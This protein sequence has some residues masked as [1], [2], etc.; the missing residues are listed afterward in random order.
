VGANVPTI[1]R[2]LAVNPADPIDVATMNFAKTAM[3][4]VV[5]PGFNVPIPYSI[6]YGY[7]DLS[8]N[9]PAYDLWLYDRPTTFWKLYL[10]SGNTKFR[11]HALRLVPIYYERI[12]SNGRMRGTDWEGDTKYSY[13]D[14]LVWYES[15]TGDRQF[16]AKADL[17][18]NHHLQ[19]VSKTSVVDGFTERN[20]GYA[21]GAMLSH[22]ALTQDPTSLQHAR[23]YFEFLVTLASASGAPLHTVS[24]HGEGDS[25]AL[26]TSLWMG[27]I[28][29]EY[30]Q[31]YH[32]ITGDRRALTW[33]S[34]YAD[35]CVAFG[36]YDPAVGNSE[37]GQISEISGGLVPWYLAGPS[38]KFTDSGVYSDVEHA[39][40]VSSLLAKGV[41][42]KRKLGLPVDAALTAYRKLLVSAQWCFEYWTRDTLTLPKYRL[43][44]ARKFGWW[45]ANSYSNSFNVL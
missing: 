1:N 37:T 2:T 44:P 17:I 10:R 34:R 45:F 26:C 31:T 27:S 40:D 38:L 30:V 11:D 16:R 8:P 7:V 19:Y 28:V 42:A 32:G 33:L 20:F 9:T 35:F 14:P 15:Q 24:Q 3:N 18:R 22:Y 25:S 5:E 29:A 23:D 6:D 13:I 4:D 36:L 43:V 39:M 21:L 41:W 12:L